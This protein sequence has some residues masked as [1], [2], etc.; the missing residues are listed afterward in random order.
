MTWNELKSRLAVKSAGGS[1]DPAVTGVTCDSRNAA[2]GTLFVS[3]P[4]FR[5]DGD[6]FIKNAIDKGACAVLSEKAQPWCPVPWAQ[7]DNARQ[8]LGIVSRL[9]YDIDLS[10]VTMVAVTGTNGKTTTAHLFRSLLSQ[11]FGENGAWMFGT[12]KYLAGGISRDALNTTPE[13]AEIF[14]MMG[15]AAKKPKAVVMEASSHSLSLDRVSGLEYDCAVFTNLTQD[16]LDF[17]ET[18]ENYYQAKKLLFVDY[19]KPRGTCVINTDDPWGAR[20]AGELDGKK[21][22][23]FGKNAGADVRIGGWKCS[24]DATAVDVSVAGAPLSFE[25]KLVGFFNVYNMTAL[26][27]GAYALGMGEEA[28]R[29]CFASVETVAGRMDRVA[30]SAPFSVFVDYAHTP[31]ALVNVLSTVKELTKGRL[32]CVFGC[33]GDRDK[34]KRPLMAQAVVENADEAVVTS[35]NPR[36]EDPHAILRDVLAGMPLDF[37]HTVIADRREAIRK[38][39]TIARAGDCVVVA[40]KGHESYQEIKGVRQ[41]F[42]DKEEIVKAY[43]EM[44]G[45]ATR[46]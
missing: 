24:W 32:I 9:V 15:T 1:A 44:Q 18:M 17:H 37:P 23:T 22:I 35:D 8:N 2:P 29:R 11:K 14:R 4:G 33:G 3:I 43:R 30:L 21:V 42:D 38:A 39:L 20:L 26:I 31:D 7:V 45:D 41:H 46:G 10:A 19:L 27:A 25:S 13:A 16:H 36:G 34:K 40:G 6:G 5:V 12:I 28:V